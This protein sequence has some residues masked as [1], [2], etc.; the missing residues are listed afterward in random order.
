VISEVS[1]SL[2]LLI[3]AGLLI[4]S[5]RHS[6]L[7]NPGFNLHNVVSMRMS[8]PNTTYPKPEAVTG[9]YKQLCDRVNGLPGIESAGTTYSLPMSSVA[10]AWGPIVIEGYVPNDPQDSIIANQRFV[11]PGYF[12]A[13][14]VPLIKGRYLDDR[15]IKGALETAM[16]NEEMAERFWPNDDPVGK[17]LE[18]SPK[19]PWRTVVGIVRDTKQFSV[20][21]EPPITVYFPS[22]QFA[23]NSLYLVARASTDAGQAATAITEEIR[24]LDPELP[25]FDVKSMEER[26]HDSLARR[27]FAMLLLGLFAALALILAAIGIYGVLAYTV[28]QRTHEIGIRMALGA[29]PGDILHLVIRQAVILVS[30]GIVIGL[31]GAFALTRVLASLLFGVS[32]TD[33]LTFT[34]ISLLLGG[35]ALVASYVPARRAARVD[36][37]VALRYE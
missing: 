34:V 13:M 8:L 3:G 24:K 7:A 31:G 32:T 21:N 30:I 2:V 1:L 16:V 12:A 6:Q 25:V 9:F 20:D 4:R 15:D 26:L 18:L 22:G 33:S 29:Q 5:Y 11:S 36:P 35:I 37:M 28:N 19:G 10:L 14:G 23:I 17:R 27:R